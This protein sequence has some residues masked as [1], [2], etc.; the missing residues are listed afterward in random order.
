MRLSQRLESPLATSS[1]MFLLMALSCS[2]RRL[3]AMKRVTGTLFICHGVHLVGVNF[4]L[5]SSQTSK[6]L[7]IKQ[8]GWCMLLAWMLCT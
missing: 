1:W 7:S 2:F 4:V 5:W 3:L 8:G 6:A